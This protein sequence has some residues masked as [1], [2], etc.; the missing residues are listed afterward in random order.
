MTI[1]EFDATG[2]GGNMKA[3]HQ[4]GNV[5]LI[6]S[7]NLEEKLVGLRGMGSDPE[8][9]DWVRCEN[10]TLMQAAKRTDS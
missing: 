9:V 8:E 5:Y 7:V 1:E 2:W 10:V 4:D 6:A 3:R